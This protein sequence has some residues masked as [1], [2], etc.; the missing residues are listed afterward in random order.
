MKHLDRRFITNLGIRYHDRMQNTRRDFSDDELIDELTLRSYDD[1]ITEKRGDRHTRN[2][3]LFD[4]Y[5][6]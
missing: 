6:K 2:A 4:F 3:I 5:G 1:R